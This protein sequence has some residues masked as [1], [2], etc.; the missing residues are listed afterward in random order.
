MRVSEDLKTGLSGSIGQRCP[1]EVDD[2]RKLP[3]YQNSRMA[4]L[5]RL[6][7]LVDWEKKLA[8]PSNAYIP[9]GRASASLPSAIP[10]CEKC[11]RRKELRRNCMKKGLLGRFQ[12]VRK[13]N[14]ISLD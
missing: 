1:I 12:N 10:P 7:S 5:L 6:E 9:T 3:H 2:L 14:A 13:M 4:S 11:R 8:G